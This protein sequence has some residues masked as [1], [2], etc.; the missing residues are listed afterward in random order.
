MRSLTLLMFALASPALAHENAGLALEPAAATAAADAGQVSAPVVDAGTAAVPVTVAA[1]FGQGV[2]VR[3]GDFSFNVRG[4]VQV[5]GVAVVPTPGSTALRANDILVRRA[6]I[7]IKGEGPFKLSFALQLA[8][9]NLDM[10]P[11]APNV[12]RD[13]YLDWK[14]LRDVWLR[15]G[16]TKVPFGVQRVTSSSSLGMVDRSIATAEFNLDRDVGLTGSSDDLLGLGGRLRYRLGVFGGDGRN[17]TVANNGLLYVARLRLSNVGWEDKVEGDVDLDDQFRVALGGSIARNNQTNRPR[18][19]TG[20]PFQAA[21]FNYSHIGADLQLRWRGASL[22]SE[23]YWRR[24]DQNSATNIVKGAELT[25]FS[26]SGLS[27][28]VQ[29]GFYATRLLEFVARYGE[30]R[31]SSGTDPN[32]GRTREIGGGVNIMVLSHDLKVQADYFWL[33][34]AAGGNG[35]HQIRLQ[36]QAYF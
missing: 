25:E 21:T 34:N 22:L 2:T 13:F 20:L 27:W 7:A 5:Q 6:R 18:S 1:K 31:P 23:F 11:D 16:Q 14:P 29:A 17:R 4:R 36:V 30:V 26:R 10:E 15:L 32:F 8:F 35:R 24:A 28:F 3:A 12:L 9:A 19:T 33:D